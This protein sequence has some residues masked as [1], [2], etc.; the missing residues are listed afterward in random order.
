MRQ[1]LATAGQQ[2]DALLHLR[3]L[4]ESIK[5]RSKFC[6]LLQQ[7]CADLLMFA[8]KDH[9]DAPALTDFMR[10]RCPHIDA[11]SGLS[12]QSS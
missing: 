12:A 3:G 11:V 2:P 6:C 4:P 10:K 8:L 9:R 7:S 1:P 5:A